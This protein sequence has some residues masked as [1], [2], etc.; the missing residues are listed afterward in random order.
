MPCGCF[1]IIG[2][3]SS[4]IE[5]AKYSKIACEYI[6]PEINQLETG[7]RILI[8]VRPSRKTIISVSPQPGITAQ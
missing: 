2:V 7:L 1:R 6:V 5:E 4:G 3:N 8:Q